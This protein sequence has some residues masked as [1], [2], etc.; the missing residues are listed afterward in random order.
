MLKGGK[1]TAVVSGNRRK[2]QTTY[3]DGTEMVEEFDLQTD[4]LLLRKIRRPTSVG[5]Q[6]PWVFEIGEPQ[7][8]SAEVMGIAESS[9]NPIVVR[10]DTEKAF[11][12]RIRN[13]HY[14]SS[15]FAVAVEPAERRIVVRTSNKKYFKKLEV[16]D[17]E[18]AGL[19]LEPAALS[20]QHTGDTLIISYIKPGPILEQ[21]RQRKLE[22]LRMKSDKAPKDGD[23]ECSQQ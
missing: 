8:V 12:W 20:W 10:K 17:M 23:V 7:R 1:S 2:V 16:P 5:G 18:R 22:R 19:A 4:E 9:T 21:E 11:Q 15:V 6:G 14:P 3:D 13:L